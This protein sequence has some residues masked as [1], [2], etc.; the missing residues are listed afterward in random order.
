MNPRQLPDGPNAA[1]P[2]REAT[3]GAGLGMKIRAVLACTLLTGCVMYYDPPVKADHAA[4]KYKTDLSRC[5][6]Q[7]T[8][9][10]ERLANA[11][12]GKA[13]IS[14]F[15]SDDPQRHDI[16]TCMNGKGYASE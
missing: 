1:R 6:K 15:R 5:Q 3:L 8:L 10:A 7:V 4:P 12:V 2:A 14:L 13:I 16:Q 9:P 11:T